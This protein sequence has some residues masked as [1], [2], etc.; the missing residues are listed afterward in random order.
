MSFKRW[1]MVFDPVKIQCTHCGARLKLTTHWRNRYHLISITIA[2]VIVAPT[3]LSYFDFLPFAYLNQ[4]FI[5]AGVL[6]IL[7]LIALSAFFWKRFE[8][9]HDR[10]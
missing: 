1:L 2:V 10:E 3:F 4:F 9:L 6:V 8:Y 5:I 7:S